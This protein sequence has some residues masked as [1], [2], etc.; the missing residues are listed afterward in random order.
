MRKDVTKLLNFLL[1]LVIGLTG[2]GVFHYYIDPQLNSSSTSWAVG[3]CFS[4][5]FDSLRKIKNL[6]KYSVLNEDSY[7][8]E[9]IRT[10]EDLKL[11]KKVDCFDFFDEKTK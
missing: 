3:D 7:E 8:K 11:R 2:S 4:T 5:E 10:Y 1:G 9:Y 6:G